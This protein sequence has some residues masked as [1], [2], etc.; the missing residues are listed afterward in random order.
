MTPD[1]KQIAQVAEDATAL[2]KTL[3][4]PA[5]LTICC[6]LQSEEMSVSAIESR[7]GIK[8]PSLSRELARLREGGFVETRRESKVIYYRLTDDPQIFALID[9][10]CAVM[11]DRVAST[12]RPRSLHRPNAHAGCGLFA[13][14][15]PELSANSMN[16][17][18]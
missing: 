6:Q 7:L 9:A 10:V 3:A 14:V 12:P 11:L 5:R 16:E 18:L 8:Q 17:T 4:H 15:E 2:L 1:T 13:R